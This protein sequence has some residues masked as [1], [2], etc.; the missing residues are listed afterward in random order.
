M[1]VK[2]PFFPLCYVLYT[3]VTK[4]GSLGPVTIVDI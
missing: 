2:D 3:A 4:N 1:A